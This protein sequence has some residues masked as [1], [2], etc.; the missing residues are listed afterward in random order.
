M[1]KAYRLILLVSLF[2]CQKGIACFCDS[3]DIETANYSVYEELF[4]G[5]VLNIKRIEITKAYKKEAYEFVGT[6]T[7]FEVIKKWKGRIN[8]I[9][10]IYQE[11]NSCAIDF[12][13]TN[14]RWIISAYRKPFVSDIFKKEYPG[15]YL[16][17]DNCSLY[18][19]EL[20]YG[21]FENDIVKIDEKFP[22]K[23][24]LKETSNKW[25]WILIFGLSVII[26][27]NMMKLNRKRNYLNN[28]TSTL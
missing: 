22:D 10:E 16:Q 13:I 3:E 2:F 8:K 15:E 26:F 1:K 19:E 14:R 12:S 24:T 20:N 4:L 23:I 17:T 18:V 7:T 6:M 5:K 28:K 25:I 27:K 9:I 11:Q 21:K